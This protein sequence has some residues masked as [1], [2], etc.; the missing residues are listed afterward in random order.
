[1]HNAG[2][3]ALFSGARYLRWNVE[4]EDYELGKPCI[5]QADLHYFLEHDICRE[6]YR[7]DSNKKTLGRLVL[8][9]GAQL[10]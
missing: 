9:R 3:S 2:R 4:Q 7:S 1:V 8:L 5:M 10:Q 6:M